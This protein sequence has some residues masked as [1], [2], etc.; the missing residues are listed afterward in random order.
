MDELINVDSNNYLLGAALGS[1]WWRS[2]P[3]LHLNPWLRVQVRE[4]GWEAFRHRLEVWD[5]RVGFSLLLYGCGDNWR[6]CSATRTLESTELHCRVLWRRNHNY[7]LDEKLPFL[8]YKFCSVG[9]DDYPIAPR[10]SVV[11]QTQGSW[12]AVKSQYGSGWEGP[13][14]EGATSL[15]PLFVGSSCLSPPP[16]CCPSEPGGRSHSSLRVH[17]YFSQYCLKTN[18]HKSN[19]K[20]LQCKCN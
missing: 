14:L 5:F 16:P 11:G 12:W 9:G 15:G 3:F 2:W 1:G 13:D 6:T 8:F 20:A 7:T 17:R 18:F 19:D 10:S 4:A